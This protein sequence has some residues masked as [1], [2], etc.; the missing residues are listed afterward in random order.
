MINECLC[1]TQEAWKFVFWLKK[2]VLKKSYKS[3]D[4]C[5]FKALDLHISLQYALKKDIKNYTLNKT[6]NWYTRCVNFFSDAS[7]RKASCSQMLQ[8]GT[9]QHD[10]ICKLD[11]VHEKHFKFNRDRLWTK[12]NALC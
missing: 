3:C 12:L 1:Y 9:K 4:Y 2:Y 11:T 8:H 7:L 5:Q 6:I 10:H